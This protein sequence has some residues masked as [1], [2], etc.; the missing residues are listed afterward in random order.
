VNQCTKKATKHLLQWM[1]H[2]HCCWST[3]LFP[4]EDRSEHYY[5]KAILSQC[6]VVLMLRKAEKIQ[7]CFCKEITYNACN[8]NKCT[9]LLSWLLVRIATASGCKVQQRLVKGGDG[10]RYHS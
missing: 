8:L 9:A 5:Y 1:K 7:L 10:Q 4:H 3:V 2:I 6:T